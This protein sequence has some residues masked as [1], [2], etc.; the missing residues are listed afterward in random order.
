M[1]E[2]VKCADCDRTLRV[3][4]DLLGKLV[5]CPSCKVT[6][7]AT[8]GEAPPPDEPQIT[9]E[10]HVSPRGASRRGDTVD[11]RRPRRRGDDEDRLPPSDEDYADDDEIEEVAARRRRRAPRGTRAEWRRAKQGLGYLLWAVIVLISS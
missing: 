8:V 1:P 4:D 3:P 7:T 11:E 2:N 5:R 9:E 10:E 6:F